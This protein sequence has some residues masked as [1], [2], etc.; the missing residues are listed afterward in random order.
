MFLVTKIEC[1]YEVI[2]KLKITPVPK[3]CPIWDI[4]NIKYLIHDIL[5]LEVIFNQYF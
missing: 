2:I 1:K 5:Q 3:L 4:H